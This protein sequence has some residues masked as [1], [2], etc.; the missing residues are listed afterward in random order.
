MIYGTYHLPSL[1]TRAIRDGE[2]QRSGMGY[3]AAWLDATGRIHAAAGHVPGAHALGYPG[4]GVLFQEGYARITFQPEY[5]VGA[6]FEKLT[7][8][9]V[10]HLLGLWHSGKVHRAST[11]NLAL[12][13]GGMFETVKD[14]SH[15]LRQ[16]VK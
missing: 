13:D 5:E 10:D 6:E 11:W 7:S 2:V 15:H 4:M 9:Q 1:Y 3:Y 8:K 12:G 16:A 14:Y